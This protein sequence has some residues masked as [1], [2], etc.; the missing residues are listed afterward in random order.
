MDKK[1]TKHRVEHYRL[2]D[3]DDL[4]DSPGPLEPKPECKP[5][6]TPQDA[7]PAP[8][9]PKETGLWRTFALPVT[10]SEVSGPELW[11]N[12]FASILLTLDTEAPEDS[13]RLELETLLRIVAADDFT[14]WALA[15][16]AHMHYAI[17]ETLAVL[18]S[19]IASLPQISAQ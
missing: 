6:T 5:V 9:L 2:D 8:S 4:E 12:F 13:L 17:F 19:L 18:N 10:P 1:K 3:L 14:E 7:P 11:R 16:T 15:E